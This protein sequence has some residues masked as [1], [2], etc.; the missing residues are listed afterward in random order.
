MKTVEVFALTWEDIDYEK[1]IIH[2]KHSLY[3][4]PRDDKGRWYIGTTKTISGTR[5]VYIRTTL[6]EALKNFKK[7]QD[8]LKKIYDK[9][10][11]IIIK[12]KLQIVMVK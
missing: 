9:K 11:F 7:K 10:Y 12:N 5:D 6:L 4:K 2:I 8:Y 3:D 1:R